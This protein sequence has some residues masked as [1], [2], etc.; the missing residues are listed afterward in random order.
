MLQGGAGHPQQAGGSAGAR[1]PAARQ[2]QGSED[3]LLFIL[4]QRAQPLLFGRGLRTG[5][6]PLGQGT[7]RLPGCIAF[8]VR[9]MEE[10]FHQMLIDG[11]FK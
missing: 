4:F 7:D 10:F 5:G 8:G 9:Q 11:A 3:M 6:R 1:D 2:F